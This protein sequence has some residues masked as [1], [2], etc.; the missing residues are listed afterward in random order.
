MP[1]LV[2]GL[3]AGAIFG[4]NPA[5]AVDLAAQRP[6]LSAVRPSLDPTH[7]TLPGCSRPRPM[8]TPA[9]H[10]GPLDSLL[11]AYEANGPTAFETSVTSEKKFDDLRGG[12]F[13]TLAR[14]SERP[15]AVQ[16]VFLLEFA[17]YALTHRYFYWVD[18]LD[19]ARRFEVAR[20]DLPGS[21]AADDEFE[22]LWHKTAFALLSLS[23]RPE[24]I[25]DCGVTP[26]V[27]RIAAAPAGEARLIDPWIELAAGIADE[28]WAI[29]DDRDLAAR[30]P[31]ALQHFDEASRFPTTRTEALVRKSR[32]L[33][34]LGRVQE[35][36][37]ALRSTEDATTDPY[38][39]YWA[40]LFTGTSLALLGDEP[41]ATRA[42]QS[43]LDLAPGAQSASLGLMALSFTRDH[44][45]DAYQ[46][47]TDVR[48]GSDVMDPW[49]EYGYGDR[50]FLAS[51]LDQLRAMSRR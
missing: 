41:G 36:A 50:R 26:L 42:Y 22:L 11:A 32:V 46:R 43:A 16:G 37:D 29:F 40:R 35:A 25:E 3:V 28:F 1:R 33:V 20:R 14:W 45:S 15:R 38:V 39:R 6:D 17:Q 30:G 10:T 9:E 23:R 2:V 34:R 44:L 48:T 27:S 13:A 8:P 12:M 51:R 5:I 47:A 21:K 19:M 49:W 18:A 7:P 24:L 31:S 4:L